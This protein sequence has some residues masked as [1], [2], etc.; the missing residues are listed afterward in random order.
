[1]FMFILSYMFSF[2]KYAK[3]RSFRKKKSNILMLIWL[4]FAYE[5]EFKR[6]F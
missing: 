3:R 4:I 6:Y 5:Q 1:M 2:Y